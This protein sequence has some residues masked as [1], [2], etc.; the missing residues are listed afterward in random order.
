MRCSTL[1]CE[2]VAPSSRYSTSAT[3]PVGLRLRRIAS[4]IAAGFWNSWYTSTIR[5]QSRPPDGSF[6][7][8]SVPSTGTIPLTP[9][10]AT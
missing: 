3:F 4:S 2:A 7:S 6:G 10:A 5:I 9:S 8:V 1:M